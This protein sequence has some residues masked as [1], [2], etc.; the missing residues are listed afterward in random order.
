MAMTEGKDA[1]Q[2]LSKIL[3][4]GNT[5]VTTSFGPVDGMP[6]VKPMKPQALANEAKIAQPATKTIHIP[7]RGVLR[8]LSVAKHITQE[9]QPIILTGSLYLVGDFHREM[10]VR[11]SIDWWLQPGQAGDRAAIMMLDAE[12]QQRVTSMLSSEI[13]RGLYRHGGIL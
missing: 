8:A 13:P 11:K 4:P 9:Q 3:Q 12:G 1:Q 7:E 2:Y 6:W 5:V 10:K